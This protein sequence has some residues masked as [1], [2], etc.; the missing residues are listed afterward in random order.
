[1]LLF[2][3]LGFWSFGLVLSGKTT[4]AQGFLVFFD[5]LWLWDGF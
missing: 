1:M 3:G 5:L 4:P 2:L